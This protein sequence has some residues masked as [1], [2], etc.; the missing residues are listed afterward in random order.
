M[1]TLDTSRSILKLEDFYFSN[2]QF[3]RNDSFTNYDDKDVEISLGKKIETADGKLVVQIAL[4][5]YLKDHFELNLVAIGNFSCSSTDTNVELFQ[6]NAI[7][8]MFPYIR[9]EVTLLT[10]QPNMKPIMLPPININALFEH[11]DKINSSDE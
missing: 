6:K 2:I 11:Q 3:T 7:A 5:S 9:S 10:A 8:I 4:R 1:P